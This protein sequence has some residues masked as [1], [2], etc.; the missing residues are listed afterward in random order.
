MCGQQIHVP[1]DASPRDGVRAR[2]GHHES[3]KLPLCQKH[4]GA[5]L[6]ALPPYGVEQSRVAGKAAMHTTRMRSS[7]L[8]HLADCAR[9]A[10]LDARLTGMRLHESVADCMMAGYARARRAGCATGVTR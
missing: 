5:A 10:P 4:N 7:A 2:N 6:H 9:L 8:A 1:R 3:L